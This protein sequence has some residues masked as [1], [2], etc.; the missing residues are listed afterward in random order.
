MG[1]MDAFTERIRQYPAKEQAELRVRVNIPGSWFG[2]LTPAESSVVYEGEACGFEDAYRFSRKGYR[3]AFVS[4]AVRFICK[5]DAQDDPNA[6]SFIMPIVEWNRYRHFTYKDDR[7]A[8]MPY[9]RSS[10]VLTAAESPARPTKEAGT[11]PAI[12][13]EFEFLSTGRHTVSKRNGT[14][15]EHDCEF[16]KCLNT[17]GSCKTRTP[18]KVVNKASGKLFAHLKVCNVAA[19]TRI[20]LLEAGQCQDEHGNLIPRLSFSEMLPHHIEFTLMVVMEWDHLW[21]C[22]SPFRKKW[23]RGLRP[24]ASLPHRNTC[25][26]IMHVIRELMARKLMKVIQATQAELGTPFAGAQDDVWS[27]RNCREVCTY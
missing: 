22:R 1:G 5:S 3:Q 24:G 8:E 21:K 4:E 6:V 20:K 16:W 7:E 13:T 19:H 12:Y 26:K 17:G 11:R 14:S 10:G 23:A 25:I 9:L 15:K 2:G 18:F 27:Q